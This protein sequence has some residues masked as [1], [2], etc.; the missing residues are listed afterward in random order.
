MGKLGA[1]RRWISTLHGIDSLFVVCRF[2]PG[3][4]EKV[5]TKG[6][7]EEE[8]GL[9]TRGERHCSHMKEYMYGKAMNVTWE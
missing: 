1:R 8:T 3:M 6:N 4:P 9:D 2:L 7:E 5:E